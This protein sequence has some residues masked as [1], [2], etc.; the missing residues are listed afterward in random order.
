[1]KE[2]KVLPNFDYKKPLG[3]DLAILVLI[4]EFNFNTCSIR[5]A[6]LPPPGFW[7]KENCNT[8][9]VL[10]YR[11]IFQKVS[12]RR[13]PCYA[14]GWGLVVSRSRNDS[15]RSELRRVQTELCWPREYSKMCNF[16]TNVPYSHT[17][18]A[19]RWDYKMRVVMSSNTLKN[20][21]F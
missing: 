10:K 4:E 14:Y 6:T 7:P 12:V 1:M 15:I 9:K 19:K 2:I 16:N 18:C 13:Q 11:V 8:L 3:V 20:E 5:P 17:I 21:Q